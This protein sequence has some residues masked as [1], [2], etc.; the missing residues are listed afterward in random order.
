MSIGAKHATAPVRHGSRYGQL[1][2]YITTLVNHLFGLIKEPRTLVGRKLSRA[3][4]ARCKPRRSVSAHG[5]VIDY[6]GVHKHRHRHSRTRKIHAVYYKPLAHVDAPA[7]RPPRPKAKQPRAQSTSPAPHPLG[8]VVLACVVIGTAGI[9]CCTSAAPVPS[10]PPIP[11]P[12]RLA[13]VAAPSL[14]TRVLSTTDGPHSLPLTPPLKAEC[15]AT[16]QGLAIAGAT[17]AGFC[18]STA[19]CPS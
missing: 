13:H 5:W 16:P 2:L 1:P 19:P 17:G 3:E 8:P 14:P 18:S 6:R 7:R 11:Q 15:P 10:G 12:W 9:T 4:H